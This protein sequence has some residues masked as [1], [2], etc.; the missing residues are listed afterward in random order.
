[1][2]AYNRKHT[3][4]P[5]PLSNHASCVITFTKNEK[6]F[7]QI[8]CNDI[9]WNENIAFWSKTNKSLTLQHIGLECGHRNRKHDQATT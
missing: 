2:W 9:K 5:P 6:K 4:T 3:R 8:A 1:M 7:S